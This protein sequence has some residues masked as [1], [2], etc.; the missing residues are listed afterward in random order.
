MNPNQGLTFTDSHL[1]LLH[2]AH[3]AQPLSTNGGITNAFAV[4]ALIYLRYFLLLPGE[5]PSRVF[6]RSVGWAVN[7]FNL[8]LGTNARALVRR[9][10]Y[11]KIWAES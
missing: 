4:P 8:V 7:L 5:R 10:D 6:D 11:E 9:H 1:S 3:L 2:K